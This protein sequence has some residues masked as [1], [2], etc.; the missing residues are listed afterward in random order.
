MTIG[1]N[2]NIERNI[3]HSYTVHK[4]QP[5]IHF[6]EKQR[7]LPS[8]IQLIRPVNIVP[9]FMLSFMGGWIV[10]PTPIL[11]LE[12]QFWVS[13]LITQLIMS[14]SMVVNDIYDI[15][16]DR[17]NNPNRPLPSG[18][19][20]LVTATVLTGILFTSA[21]ILGSVYFPNTKLFYSVFASILMLILY[22]P[23][24]K[25]IC[26]VKNLICGFIVSGSIAFSG[27]AM[28]GQNNLKLL[29]SIIRLVC[30]SS[31]HM[32]LLNDI[33]DYDGDKLSNIFTVPVL[34]GKPAAGIMSKTILYIGVFD[35][36]M[37]SLSYPLLITYGIAIACSP[38]LTNIIV[39]ELYDFSK[40]SV[41]IAVNGTTVSLF[42]NMIIFCYAATLN[43]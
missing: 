18:K 16:V 25:R 14:G 12:K 30:A 28:G 8:L 36:I 29:S 40:E 22:T 7:Q 17:K 35:A 31:I 13:A 1:P 11:L 3:R 6:N 10:Q 15:D 38:M 37:V 41:K 32:E 20:K 4:H 24:F 33:R 21:F 43:L 26:F 9:T 5:T 23:F 42:L 27:F 2:H 19:V 34:F 39:C